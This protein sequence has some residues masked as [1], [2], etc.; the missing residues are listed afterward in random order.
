[1]NTGSAREV[2]ILAG[3]YGTR[4]RS[5]VPDIPKVLAPV[6]GRPFLVHVLGFLEQNG[7]SRVI[8]AVGYRRDEITSAFGMNFRKL[9]L[10]YSVE[11]Q[12]LGT[13]GA[14]WS[15]SHLITTGQNF[16]VLNGD[17]YAAVDIEAMERSMS[18]QE[19]DLVMTVRSMEDTKRYGLVDVNDEGLVRGFHEKAAGS[20]GLINAGVY[21]I[22]HDLPRRFPFAG[23][24]S[25]ETDL[26]QARCS[27]LRIAA[28][29]THGYFV[30]IG[31]PDDYERANRDLA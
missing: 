29:P 20:A 7:F 9:K 19:A 8:L 26:L 31:V 17:T 2:I 15:A 16:F 23:A 28:L 1:M 4:L 22:R 24:F 21:L 25:L 12:P 13:G 5:A 11:E 27:S 10:D 6:A 3:G 14:V 30:D 18:E